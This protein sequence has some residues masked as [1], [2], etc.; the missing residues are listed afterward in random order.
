MCDGTEMVHA[1]FVLKV[2]LLR[3]INWLLIL[4]GG[5]AIYFIVH[6]HQNAE[7]FS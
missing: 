7:Y 4:E 6:E 5:K 1:K 2:G 3:W